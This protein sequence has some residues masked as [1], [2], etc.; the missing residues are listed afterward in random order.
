MDSWWQFGEG[1]GLRGDKM[2][3]YEVTCPFCREKGNFEVVFEAE[4]K[5]PNSNKTL[6]FDTWKCNSCA[7]FV[8]VFWSAA[9]WG[10][11]YSYKVQ[12][13]PTKVEG[14]PPYW[15]HTV[16]RYWVQAK[17]SLADENFDAAV[18]MARSALQSALRDQGAAGR[19]LKSEIDD[20]ATKGLLPSI[21]KEWSNNVR[22]LGNESA[23]PS[24]EQEP[25]EPLDARD[26]VQF[27]D[28]L[29]QYLYNLPHQIEEYRGRKRAGDL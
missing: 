1:S 15:P 6:H 7:A 13:W 20:L 14:F 19:N 3:Q 4:K 17:R 11:L 29:L 24:P 10:G 26:I 2:K 22:E 9:E 27:L 5:K 18:L 23:H 8:Q 12:P 21:M 25:T 28:Y 16:G